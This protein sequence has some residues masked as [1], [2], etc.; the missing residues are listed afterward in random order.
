MSQPTAFLSCACGPQLSRASAPFHIIILLEPLAPFD[1]LQHTIGLY[2]L[3]PNVGRYTTGVWTRQY[4]EQQ[5]VMIL[6]GRAAE[7]LVFGR[8]EMSS[9][10]QHKIMQAR[11]VTSGHDKRQ[12]QDIIEDNKDK[13]GVAVSGFSMFSCRCNSSGAVRLHLLS[14]HA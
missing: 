11:Q 10:H 14:H 13:I 3:Q 1:A 8:E 4:L 5:L 12:G 7:E 6:A 2:V 9:L